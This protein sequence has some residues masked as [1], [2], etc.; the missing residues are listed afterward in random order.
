MEQKFEALKKEDP[1]QLRDSFEFVKSSVKDGSYFRDGLEWYLFRYVNPVCQRT[2]LSIAGIV[3]FIVCYALINMISS[4]FPLVQKDPIII[5]AYDSSRYFP[6]L[7]PLKP[8]EKGMGS[9]KY[10]PNVTTVDEA[11]LK[12]LLSIYIKD[13]ESYDYSKAEIEDVNTKFARIRNTSNEAEYREFQLYMSKDNPQSPVL[14]FGKNV[15]RD[16]NILSVRF[17]RKEST[18]LAGKARDF[19]S[20]KIPNQAEV[21]FT[22]ILKTTD[23]NGSVKSENQNYLAKISFSF[24]GAAKIDKNDK[25]SDRNLGFVVKSYKLF[26]VN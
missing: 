26:K 20:T 2:I 14:N 8:H 11:V 17:I 19:I 25:N 21:R 13:R 23:E 24:K 5:R 10:D 4:A 16:V 3:S 9:D 1:E 6:N 15:W 22:A 7:I 12:Y 18:D